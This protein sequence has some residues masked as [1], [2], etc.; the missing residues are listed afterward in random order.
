MTINEIK[1]TNKICKDKIVVEKMKTRIGKYKK[2]VSTP[3]ANS[4]YICTNDYPR[5]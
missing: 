2:I 4:K 3:T 1:I 5:I